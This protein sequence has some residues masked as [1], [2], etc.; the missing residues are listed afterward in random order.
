MRGLEG[1]L[2]RLEQAERQYPTQ[3]KSELAAVL[4]CMGHFERMRTIDALMSRDGARIMEGCSLL[5]RGRTRQS[6]GWTQTDKAALAKQDKDKKDALWRLTHA[7]GER[8]KLYPSVYRFDVLDL[9]EPEIKQLAAV[10]E[11]ATCASD[12]ESVAEV[13]GRLRL[14]GRIMHMA[15]FEALVLRGQIAAQPPEPDWL[16]FHRPLRNGRR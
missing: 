12:L 8:H 1:R 10:A 14:D 5:A 11:N 9:T 13:V 6:Q 3:V 2:Q 4:R 7:L 16:E 15:T